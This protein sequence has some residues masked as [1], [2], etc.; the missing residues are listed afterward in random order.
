MT[1]R[2][3][4]RRDRTTRSSPASRGSPIWYDGDSSKTCD[5]DPEDYPPTTSRRHVGY[6]D[7]CYYRLRCGHPEC[8]ETWCTFI[9]G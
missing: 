1:R 2:P 9:E 6:S 3:R 8:D 4:H 5:H 7:F